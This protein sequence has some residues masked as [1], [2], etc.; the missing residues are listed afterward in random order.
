MP[1]K[2]ELLIWLSRRVPPLFVA[3]LIQKPVS[4]WVIQ[5]FCTVQFESVLMAQEKGFPRVAL[6]RVVIAVHSM[7]RSETLVPEP[8]SVN[9][10]FP[11]NDESATGLMRFVYH[12]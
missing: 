5:T 11:V 1:R 10:I 3:P 2:I 4:V 8:F 9:P 12:M 7:C 6:L